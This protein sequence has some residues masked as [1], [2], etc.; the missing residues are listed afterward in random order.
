MNNIT[1][2]GFDFP[3]TVVNAFDRHNHLPRLAKVIEGLIDHTV[4]DAKAKQIAIELAVEYL[5]RLRA[6]VTQ[7][8]KQ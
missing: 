1:Y 4:P 8:E 6:A 5:P 3:A 7:K 2:D